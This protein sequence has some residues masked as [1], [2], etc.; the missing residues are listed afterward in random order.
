MQMQKLQKSE[1][2]YDLPERLIA[3][4]PAERRDSSRLLNI[5]RGADGVDTYSHLRFTDFPSLLNSGDLLILNDSKVFPARLHGV[6]ADTGV[7]VELLL[8][9]QVG[10][11]EWECMVHPGRRL[12]RGVVVTLSGGVRAVIGDTV[13]FGNR[14][15]R[16]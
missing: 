14:V 16:F 6:K 1:F 9:K 15:V 12:K 13:A 10:L 2:Y 4:T 5:T 11:C 7:A 3:Q 8:L